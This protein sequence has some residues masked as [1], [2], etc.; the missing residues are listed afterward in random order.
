MAGEVRI[1]S[2]YANWTDIH[3]RAIGYEFTRDT[4]D[5][6]GIRR[7]IVDG[8]RDAASCVRQLGSTHSQ[9]RGIQEAVFNDSEETLPEIMADDVRSALAQRTAGQ[10]TPVVKPISVVEKG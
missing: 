3:L 8:A 7:R 2:K 1:V 6:T 10:Q 4:P 9:I 5:L